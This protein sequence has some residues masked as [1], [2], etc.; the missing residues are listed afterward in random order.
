M[1]RPQQ[2]TLS[3]TLGAKAD[4]V[5]V[6]GRLL[7]QREICIASLRRSGARSAAVGGRVR[8]RSESV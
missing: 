4:S 6:H 8:R 1:A 7:F 5:T 3:L 2:D